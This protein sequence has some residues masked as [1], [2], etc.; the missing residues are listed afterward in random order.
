MQHSSKSLTHREPIKG[1][2]SSRIHFHTAAKVQACTLCVILQILH[3]CCFTNK[4][5]TNIDLSLDGFIAS[6]QREE[7]TGFLVD[8]G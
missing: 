8:G 2:E 5:R 6:D 3:F 4:D 7:K 1:L